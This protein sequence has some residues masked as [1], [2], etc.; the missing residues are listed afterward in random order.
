MRT[1][2]SRIITSGQLFVFLFIAKITEIFLYPYSF[3]S[4]VS[5]WYL[6]LPVT[7]NIIL[8]FLLLIP[9]S[10]C[11]IYQEENIVK[12]FNKYK[13]FS[14]LFLIY[15]SFI[16]LLFLYRLYRFI[17]E[18]AN[19]E[20]NPYLI[21]FIVFVASLYSAFKGFESTVRFSAIC[22]ILVIIGAVITSFFLFPSYDSNV[23]SPIDKDVINKLP[24]SF[25]LTLSESAEL[26]LLIY[27]SS[28]TKGNFSKSFILWNIFQGIFILFMIILISGAI[29]KYLIGTEFPF[30]HVIDGS[31]V[32]QR[33]N[34]LFISLII[35]VFVC[36]VSAEL[37]IMRESLHG[38]L[39]DFK[40][41]KI[42]TYIFS[43]SIFSL[44]LI[45]TNNDRMAYIL[46]NRH[47]L[48]LSIVLIAIIIPV[49]VFIIGKIKTGI[50]Y[51]SK[52]K[53]SLSVFLLF[54]IIS[55]IFSGCAGTQ[56]NQRMIIQGIGI[57]KTDNQYKLSIISLDTENE[58]SENAV[59]I[60]YCVGKSVEQALYN[61]EMKTGKKI[62][63]SQCLFIIL[64]SDAA[65]NLNSSLDVFC[66]NKE[67]MKTTNIMVT[68]DSAESLIKTSI[69][70]SGYH[71]EDINVISDSNA[72]SQ[73]V[74]HFSILD[75]IINKHDN[76]SDILLPVIIFDENTNSLITDGS[77]AIRKD[78]QGM[79][80]LNNT[81]TLSVLLVN[82]KV[83]GYTGT[84]QK[85]NIPYKI[86]STV[87]DIVSEITEDHLSIDIKMRINLSSNNYKYEIIDSISKNIENTIR[88]LIIDKNI[89]VINV[90]SIVI[91][92]NKNSMD[93][94]VWRKLLS[95]SKISIE[96][97]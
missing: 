67:L 62:L 3:D 1:L 46:F 27:Y 22:F 49:T 91:E 8:S 54:S 36:T 24:D 18:Y 97:N 73:P 41:E 32:L 90:S 75:Y 65:K 13:S 44:F 30:Y 48:L 55:A 43:V 81:E 39:N 6:I 58:N 40:K 4:S 15:S 92:N 84:D 37:F 72:I 69:E 23:L 86:N 7:I 60:N 66:D 10:S 2:D 76:Y 9:L 93:P 83:S 89:D 74:V 31:G 21:V 42:L 25:I 45:L 29:G 20:L 78:N 80:K 51:N 34:P 64:N 96:I 11:R 79:Y 12:S 35:S 33:L 88:K 95:E 77:A 63:L 57:D 61:S 70:K 59:K 19:A 50:I 14:V 82:E 28:Y 38:I 68:E 87:S 52:V 17:K 53:K 85:Q 94:S 26:I 56:L 5:L 71:S 16:C 47:I